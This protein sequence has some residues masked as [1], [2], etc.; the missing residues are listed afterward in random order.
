[1][2]ITVTG[3]KSSRTQACLFPLTEKIWQFGH[4]DGINHGGWEVSLDDLPAV[5]TYNKVR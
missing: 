5:K 1:M 3:V 2:L 4:A